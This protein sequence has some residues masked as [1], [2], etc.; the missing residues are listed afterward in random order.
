MD[1]AWLREFRRKLLSFPTAKGQDGADELAQGL[2][3]PKEL[4]IFK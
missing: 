2:E 4:E 1:T 3:R